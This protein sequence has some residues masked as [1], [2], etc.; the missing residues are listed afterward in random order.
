M[1]ET[2]QDGDT[3]AAIM[4]ATYRALCDHGYPDTSISTIAD[5][6]DKSRSL[7]YY[8]YEDK[9]E[10]LAD[11]LRYLLDQLEADLQTIEA[12]DP[13]GEVLAIV[14]RLLPPDIESERFRF[15]RAL[16]GMRSQ[17]PYV[18]AYRE[19]FARSDALILAELT[20]AVERGIDA[21]T[22]RPVDADKVAQFV[23]AAVSGA[24][25]RSVT[26]DD[27]EMIEHHRT[28]IESYLQ[29]QVMDRED[30]PS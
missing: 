14:E 22:F 24:L 30:E 9:D 16:L 7:L 23:Y 6:F 3:T 8:H 18:D 29:S 20:D 5:E 4:E 27:P 15:Q 11:F 21:G 13:Y 25:Q 17:A 19:Q 2:G 26:L 12:D 1:S 10:L 28:L